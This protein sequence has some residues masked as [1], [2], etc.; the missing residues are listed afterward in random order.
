MPVALCPVCCARARLCRVACVTTSSARYLVDRAWPLNTNARRANESFVESLKPQQINPE[1]LYGG[2]VDA[3]SGR[4]VR[5]ADEWPI[6]LVTSKQDLKS[7]STLRGMRRVMIERASGPVVLLAVH[8]CGVLSHRAVGAALC[9]PRGRD[10]YL[11]ARGVGLHDVGHGRSFR[12]VTNPLLLWRVV[13]SR[14]RP[15]QR[16]KSKSNGRVTVV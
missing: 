9:A 7:K 6:P 12:V 5:Y 3:A 1:H 16:H 13:L 15:L 8:L 14:G 4:A 2:H 11:R 10:R